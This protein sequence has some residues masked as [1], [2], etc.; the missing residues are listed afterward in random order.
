MS[1]TYAMTLGEQVQAK[2]KA[3]CRATGF[4]ARE[5]EVEEA[6]RIMCASWSERSV[7]QFPRWSIATEDSSPI[8]ISV[9]LTQQPAEVRF[10]VEAQGDPAS[11]GSYWEAG[12]RLSHRLA[13]RYGIKL[14]RL[15]LLGDLFVPRSR[16]VPMG[17][18][19]AVG[20]G[21]VGPPRFTMYAWAAAQGPNQADWACEQ[22]FSRLGC[23]ESWAKIKAVLR[24]TDVVTFV[25]IVLDAD[26]AARVKIYV[27]HPAPFSADEYERA[28]GVVQSLQPGDAANFLR[29]MTGGQDS[30]Q[31]VPKLSFSSTR[32]V[33]TSY[34]V[35]PGRAEGID[36]VSLLF[37]HALSG[38]DDVVACERTIA[39][40]A[41]HGLPADG[42][43][44]C[45]GA[46]AP[47]SLTNQK[48][49]NSYVTFQRTRGAP[50]I[51]PYFS[52]RF[53]AERYGLI[54]RDWKVIRSWYLRQQAGSEIESIHHG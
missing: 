7:A 21:P 9:P 38:S 40:L 52:G 4:S 50:V 54:N 53:F 39:L 3:L 27:N 37:P 41:Q 30:V 20:F 8:E 2:A 29:T 25:G 15:R 43:K 32:Q 6:L 23:M 26:A 49:I 18:F 47:P 12:E 36:S 10:G 1:S 5:E 24:P 51:T 17:M 22:M 31:L 44:R 33:M 45:L 28:A 19:H 14:D 11:P 42:Y 48:Y 16:T 34:R 35:V 46:L 13:E